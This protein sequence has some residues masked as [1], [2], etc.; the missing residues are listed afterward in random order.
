MFLFYF[1]VQCSVI[2][3]TDC[4]WSPSLDWVPPPQCESTHHKFTSKQSD[5]V[6][7]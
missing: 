5:S 7:K 4:G 1:L 6:R 2:P 3:H